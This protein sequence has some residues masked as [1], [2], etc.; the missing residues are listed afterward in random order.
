MSESKSFERLQRFCRYGNAIILF[1]LAVYFFLIPGL[2]VVIDLC[3]PALRGDGIPRCAWRRHRA[4]TP[5][6]ERWARRRIASGRA[7]ELGVHNISGTEWPL[8]GSV[9]YL[10]ATKSLQEA[11]E[12]NGLKSPAP[13]E[14][15]RG[16]IVAASEL[17]LDPG[18]ATWVKRHWGE[19]YLHEEN[20]F[21]RM[22]VISAL[23]SRANLLG[24]RWKLDLLRD[25]V[26]SLA[27]ALDESP[28]GLLDD[29]PGECYPGDVVAAVAAIRRADD[30]LGTDHS[31]FV[32]RSLRAFQGE[33]VD[34]TGLPPY[35]ADSRRGVCRTR[36]RGCGNSYVA[37]FAPALWPD[38]GGRWYAHY[39]EHFWQRRWPF[40]GFREFPKDVEG[41]DFYMDVDAG[42]VVRG[43]GTAACAFGAGA[44]RVNGRF[45]HAYPLAAQM[46]AASWPLPNGTL[47]MPRV[48][49]N[50]VDAPYL[51]EAAMLY[52]LTRRPAPGVSSK[53]GGALTAFVYLLLC[54]YFGIGTAL[55]L[56]GYVRLRRARKRP[57]SEAGPAPVVQAAIWA[58]LA[59]GGVVALIVLS[60]PMALAGVGTIL[61]AQ[62]FPW[63][64]GPCRSSI[65]ESS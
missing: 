11:W 58:A 45:D 44:A 15:A 17:V 32:A 35:A 14:Y 13:R 62:L 23:T 42:P 60:W 31:S 43:F 5:E 64:A 37:L 18:H 21:Y 25:Q 1:G 39:E 10:W 59:L 9:F 52:C 49:S 24:D 48:L 27:I 12:A 16:A 55:V 65:P 51:G 38:V 40:A 47:L 28:H 19:D 6:Y 50:G 61:V 53:T 26:E 3:D 4:L 63:R 57:W 54:A 33:L 30:A 8:F 29:Y 2:S 46:I 7:E 20:V 34:S 56:L 22:L 41:R 36:V